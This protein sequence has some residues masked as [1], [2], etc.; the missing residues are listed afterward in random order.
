MRG[1]GLRNRGCSA[2]LLF[3]N[4][5]SAI[6]SEIGYHRPHGVRD[7]RSHLS[8]DNPNLLDLHADILGELLYVAL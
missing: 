5:G 1:D 2:K 8:E 6:F 7:G 3:E 4:G